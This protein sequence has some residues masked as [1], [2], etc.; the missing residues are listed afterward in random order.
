M[1]GGGK[2]IKHINKKEEEKNFHNKTA[3]GRNNDL[4]PI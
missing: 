3:Q 4:E 2:K 1:K